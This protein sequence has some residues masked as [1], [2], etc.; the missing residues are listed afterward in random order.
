MPFLPDDFVAKINQS[1]NL[2]PDERMEMFARLAE[3]V[4][5]IPVRG[6]FPSEGQATNDYKIP[7]ENGWNQW[8]ITRRPF[9][10]GGFS[11]ER[12]GIACG[13]ASG[14]LVLDIDDWDK[15]DSWCQSKSIANN[16]DTLLVQSREK[17]GHIYYK[18]P[19]DGKEY[20]N[21]K[22]KNGGFDVR[23]VGGYVI[24]PGSLHPETGGLYTILKNCDLADP[25]QWLLDFT[26]EG[27]TNN[28]EHVNKMNLF[29]NSL[30]LSDEQK[31]NIITPTPKGSRSEKSMEV[32]NAL[33]AN[34]APD[35]FI[36]NIY[37]T[38]PIGEKAREKGDKWFYDELERAKKYVETQ[39][40]PALQHNKQ[41]MTENR[42]SITVYS[43]LDV[44]QSDRQFEFMIDNVWPKGEALLITGIGGVGKSLMTLQ[45]VMDLVNPPANGFLDTYK[46]TNPSEK[47]RVIFIQSENSITGMKKRLSVIRDPRSGYAIGDTILREAIFFGGM[48]NDI[49]TTGNFE[50]GAFIE[51]LARVVEEVKADIIVVDPL[52]SFHV[53]DENSNDQMRKV[54]DTLS[55]FCRRMNVT[56]LLVHHH[57][58]I[59]SESGQ[60]GGRGAS[61]IG[62]WSPNTW[63]LTKSK[64]A[65]TLSPK[66]TRNFEPPDDLKLKLHY[67][68]FR[69]LTASD[70][71]GALAVVIRAL[72]GNSGKF[73]K[74]TDL[75]A[76]IQAILK[77]ENHDASSTNTIGTK[78]IDPAEKAGLVIKK[79]AGRSYS[80][81]INEESAKKILKK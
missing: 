49:T 53:K 79:K 17:R 63:E 46:I 64:E 19:T 7:A 45:L 60:G 32:M 43:A 68:R 5:L 8:C 33:V 36:K 65:Y 26:L 66:K 77:T 3:H 35:E 28:L 14:I 73:D 13:P 47:H 76:A 11:S 40:N 48:G 9:N 10:N 55:D 42:K 25:P 67:C 22:N 1:R 72:R 31:Q 23:G 71:G 58:K 37:D 38:Y 39:H 80:Y 50:E 75:A 34:G 56:P 54:L 16:F 4:S 81:E 74:K 12:A 20:G 70:S 44:I 69:P 29:I 15:F 6:G 41:A 62:D 52:I 57:G 59:A 61:A 51:E 30:P 2:P 78:Y 24:C 27:K 21:K 18:Y